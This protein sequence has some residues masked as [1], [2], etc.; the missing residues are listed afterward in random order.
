MTGKAERVFSKRVR[1]W[2]K[3]AQKVRSSAPAPTSCGAN[4]AAVRPR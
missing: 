2:L 4:N 1:P 3:A